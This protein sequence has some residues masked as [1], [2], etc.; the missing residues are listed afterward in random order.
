MQTEISISVWVAT[1]R[2]KPWN[3]AVL[4]YSNVETCKTIQ[5]A[6]V[7]YQLTVLNAKAKT[8]VID[9]YV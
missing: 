7:D 1:V 9:H 4:S 3:V 6:V 8:Q 5:L 2:I